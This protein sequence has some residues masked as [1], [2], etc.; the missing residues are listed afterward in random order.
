MVR[1]KQRLARA[2]I[3]GVDWYWP[4]DEHP[5]I[6]DP[7]DVVRFL[8]PFDPVVG[9]AVASS[10][11]G[12]GRTV[13]R[14]TPQCPSG[15]SV[16][17]R[18]RCYGATASSAGATSR[19]EDGV[20]HTDI[21]YASS[22]APTETRFKRE[23]DAELERV[24]AFLGLEAAAL[25]ASVSAFACP[26]LVGGLVGLVRRV[27]A[28]QRLAGS[29]LPHDPALQALLFHRGCTVVQQRRGYQH[30]AVVIG[31]HHVIRE[32]SHTA[33]ADRL[34]PTHEREPGH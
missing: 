32:D 15:G 24:Q 34:L 26:S 25:R 17:T 18:C 30:R 5:A 28:G 3:D 31:H 7:Q 20:L 23:I 8:A 12:A 11:F 13:L 14:L 29:N 6:V 10:Y 27:Q 1:A 22:S 19:S 4:A 21:G 9:I 16:T 33:T 2:R